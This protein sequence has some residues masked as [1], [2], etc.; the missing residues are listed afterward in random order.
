MQSPL[1]SLSHLMDNQKCHEQTTNSR[2]SKRKLDDEFI[3]DRN[4]TSSDETTQQDLAS[5]VRAQVQILD[6]TVSSL[7][8]DRAIVKHSIHIL[9]ELAKNE[10]IVNLI[11][12]SGGVPALVRHLQA[13]E[14]KELSEPRPYEHEVEKGSAFTLG[15]LAIKVLIIQLFIKVNNIVGHQVLF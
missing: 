10:D 5:H 1:S 15:L 7:E 4:I 12:E 3:V 6:S 9:S 8:A 13:P 11:V 14:W 2:S